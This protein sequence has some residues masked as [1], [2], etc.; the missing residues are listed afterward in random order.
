KRI[1]TRVC[2]GCGATLRVRR[3]L[4]RRCRRRL[5]EGGAQE[6]DAHARTESRLPKAPDLEPPHARPWV[7]RGGG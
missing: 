3:G 7:H 6:F 5:R 4:C 2:A 1:T